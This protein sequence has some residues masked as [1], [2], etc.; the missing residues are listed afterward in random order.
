MWN[1]L[2]EGVTENETSMCAAYGGRTPSEKSNKCPSHKSFVVRVL[3]F[4]ISTFDLRIGCS[5]AVSFIVLLQE[6][7]GV[8][9]MEIECHRL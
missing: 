4:I 7:I 1:A 9:Y 3:S 6:F 8:S 5:I 2:H